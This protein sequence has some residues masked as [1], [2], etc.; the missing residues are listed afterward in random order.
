MVLSFFCIFCS[1]FPS[2]LSVF[3]FVSLF[4]LSHSTLP[5]PLVLDV[6]VFD[7]SFLYVFFYKTFYVLFDLLFALFFTSPSCYH[8]VIFLLLFLHFPFSFPAVLLSQICCF[9][10]SL[11][12]FHIFFISSFISTFISSSF[13]S[14]VSIS[15]PFSSLL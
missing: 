10:L 8:Y 7:F 12:S 3:L 4:F 13:S 9:S 11:I 1:L 2:F 14:I 5:F 15:L 6:A